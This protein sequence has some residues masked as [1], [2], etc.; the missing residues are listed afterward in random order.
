MITYFREILYL[1]DED[2]KKIPF[3]L[4]LF[5]VSSLL[6]LASLGLIGPYVGMVVDPNYMSEA[7]MFVINSIG[8]SVEQNN[9]LKILGIALIGTFMIKTIVAIGVNY[10]IVSFSQ[11]QQV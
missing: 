7:V 2:R 1:L 4:F 3:L 11:Q 5:L 8:V 10:M 9:L 6:D